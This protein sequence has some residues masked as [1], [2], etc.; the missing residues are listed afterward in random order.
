MSGGL[1]DVW[2]SPETRIR[3]ATRMVRRCCL[4]SCRSV[5]WKISN[6]STNRETYFPLFKNRL[7]PKSRPE[8]RVCLEW[9]GFDPDDPPEPLML[10][11]RTEGR[12]QTDSVE[13][14]P[15][16]IPDGRG[17]YV[18]CFFA[19]GVRRWCRGGIPAT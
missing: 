9:S 15:Q 17:C 12:K 18:N 3:S 6:E 4:N 5:V 1:R 11:G 2:L 13:I 16:P 8:H 19:H 7:L 10:L 14:F